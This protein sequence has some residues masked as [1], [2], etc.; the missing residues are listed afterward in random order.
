VE[1]EPV[2]GLEI[3]AE[4]Q[5]RSKMFCPCPVVDSTAAEPNRYVCPVCAGMPGTLP[6]P[7]Q[8]A[9]EWT[10]LTGL[11]LNCNIAE[12]SL[13]YRKNYFYPDL[14]S[15]YQRSMYDYPLCMNGYLEIDTPEGTKQVR[16]RRVHIEEDTGKLLHV[17]G[18]T[19]VDFNRAGVPLMEIVTEPDMRSVE[20]V[21]AFAIAL[22]TLLRYLRV[23][24]GDMEK[25]FIRFEANV[26][27]RPKGET[28]LGTRTE[29]KNLNSFRSLV[30]AVEYEIRRQIE[31]VRAGR[32][33]EQETRG[34]D[35][36]R[37][38]T[39]PQRG[40]EHAHD[41]RYF[42]EPD[43]PPLVISREWAERIRDLLPELPRARRERF[44]REYGLTRYEAD[45]LTEDQAVADYFEMA[46]R[47]AQQGDPPIEPRALAT[48]ITGELFRLMNEAGVE[49]EEVRIPPAALVDL[50][51][52][53]QQGEINL[54]TGKMVLREAFET[55][56]APRRIVEA[57]GL[58]QIRD[59]EALRAIVLRV[60][61]ENP[62]EVES[63]LRGKEG[64]LKWFVGQVMRATRGQADPQRA[65][66]LIREA[67]EARRSTGP[68]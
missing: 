2:I 63:Y 64:V 20:E 27:V 6:I 53:V 45:L 29:I 5:T 21:K 35:E 30:R 14:P 66:E 43:I 34:W 62:R 15:E 26:S 56:E 8:Q 37:G 11:A 22:R 10:I 49:I 57:K 44:E 24:S 41:Y 67:L 16:I 23:N 33:V 3:H 40:K 12:Y 19:L 58:T 47:G 65:N 17:G 55:G 9:I 48:W 32:Q 51:R 68:S 60:I 61:E 7:N 25:G 36:A 1:F 54:N 52:M 28:R 13:F 59:V 31:I 50:I 46:V 18:A 39:V 42:P 4:L 38:V